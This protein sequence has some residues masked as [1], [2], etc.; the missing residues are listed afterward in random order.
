VTRRFYLTAADLV[1]AATGGALG[2]A[3]VL[4]VAEATLRRKATQ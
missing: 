1:A 2:F 4:I 3:L